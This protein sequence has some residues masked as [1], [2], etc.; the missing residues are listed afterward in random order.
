M[1][2]LLSVWPLPHNPATN[3]AIRKSQANNPTVSSLYASRINCTSKIV[4]FQETGVLPNIFL[5]FDKRRNI[6]Y[7]VSPTEKK[8]K[9]KSVWSHLLKVILKKSQEKSFR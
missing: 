7:S 4:T 3:Y 1:H 6:F 2:K 9:D 8:K 5:F